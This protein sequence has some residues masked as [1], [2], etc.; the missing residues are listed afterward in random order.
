MV[1]SHR[2]VASL[3][4]R[5][6]LSSLPLCAA[7]GAL[8]G[9]IACR[10]PRHDT[11]TQGGA[12][13]TWFPTLRASPGVDNGG[14]LVS[15]LAAFS[16]SMASQE[17]HELLEGHAAVCADLDTQQAWWQAAEAVAGGCVLPDVT[18]GRAPTPGDFQASG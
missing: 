4:A 12:H 9:S 15:V 14:V 16:R 2:V 10:H 5:A 13:R 11:G 18:L 1:A 8:S 3:L 7:K 6:H 17:W